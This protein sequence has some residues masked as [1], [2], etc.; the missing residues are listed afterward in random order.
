MAKD[1]FKLGDMF[2]PAKNVV[3]EKPIII[4]ENREVHNKEEDQFVAAPEQRQPDPVVAPKS[5][6][7]PKPVEEKKPA[8]VAKPASAVKSYD[9]KKNLNVQLSESEYDDFTTYCKIV[10][11]SD[12][13]KVVVEF[14]KA[15][16]D[17]SR[18]VLQSFKARR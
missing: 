1:K 12:K 9:A 18:D 17:E 10:K 15:C 6:D 13:S 8:Q 7:V 2:K 3:E 4:K 11:G 5:A 14:I 16:L